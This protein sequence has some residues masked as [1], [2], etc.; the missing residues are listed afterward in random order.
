MRCPT[1]L[2]L[3]LK[4]GF[5]AKPY[6]LPP[7]TPWTEV[8]VEALRKGF[9]HEPVL[10]GEGVTIPVVPWLR[11][12]LGAE[13]LLMGFALPEDNMHGPNESI[14]LAALSAGMRT[15]AWFWELCAR[16]TGTR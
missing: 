2:I 14:S 8:A 1:G 12:S 3:S 4:R 9:G 13:A 7:S 10:R 16:F 6:G 11:E 5:N 15:S